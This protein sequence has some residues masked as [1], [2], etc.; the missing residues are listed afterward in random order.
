MAAVTTLDE[1][2]LLMD[3]PV[4][5]A[6][7]DEDGEEQQLQ[8]DDDREHNLVYGAVLPAS[9]KRRT[10][11]NL[12][13]IY[14]KETEVLQKKY[15][16]MLKSIFKYTT[17]SLNLFIITDAKSTFNAEEVARKQMRRYRKHA[18]ISLLD[19][20]DCVDKIKDIVQVMMPYFSSHPGTGGAQFKSS[21]VPY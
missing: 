12:F 7:V 2:L 21:L 16:L 18:L 15:E 1:R 11:Y 10:T 9:K 8:Q 13:V 3:D 14:T 17:I 4:A 20:D 5:M 6:A 19:V